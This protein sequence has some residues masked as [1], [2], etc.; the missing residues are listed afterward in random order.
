[1]ANHLPTFTRNPGNYAFAYYRYS[2]DAQNELSIEQQREQVHKYAEAHG[3]IIPEGYEFKDEAISGTIDDRPGFLLLQS[4]IERKRPAYLIVWK[5][6]RLSRVYIRM[7]KFEY[8]MRLLG[9]RV[10]SVTEA[11]P[12]DGM[13]RDVILSLKGIF[14]QEYIQNLSDNVSRGLNHAAKNGLYIG[15]KMLGYKGSKKQ[16]YTIDTDTAPIV[17]KIFEDYANGKPLQVIADELNN[18]G[19][20]SVYNHKFVVNSL[21]NILR[22]RAYIG[23]YRWGEYVIPGGM[24]RIVSDELFNEVQKRLKKNQRGGTGSARKLVKEDVDYWLTGHIYCG[25]CGEPLHGISGTGKKGN[26]YY[27]YTCLNHKKHKCALKNQRKEKLETIVDSVLQRLID[28]S[29]IRLEMAKIC[30]DSYEESKS[31]NRKYYIDSLKSSLKDVERKLSNFVKAISE[32]I[33]NE[34]TQKAMSELESQ[35]ALLLEKID[36]EEMIEKY[37]IKLETIIN[38]FESFVDDSEKDNIKAKLLDLFVDKIF[39]YDDKMI[40]TFHFIDDKRELSYSETMEMLENHSYLM[41]CVN[42]PEAHM[43]LNDKVRTM[44]GS[45]VNKGGQ[46]FFQ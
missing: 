43:E 11:L 6:D 34:T 2:S 36:A 5:L 7:I 15:R 26:I 4:E 1:M 28:D 29:L 30:Y 23:E 21:N 45:I 18:S 9:V 46:D 31:D 3:M 17:N 35:K 12:E 40:M 39:I 42:D 16:P 20:K 41:E 8:E 27:Y 22:N 38:Y 25:E 33:F 24:P 32:G 10:D 19:F 14:A 13:Q 37:D 44:M